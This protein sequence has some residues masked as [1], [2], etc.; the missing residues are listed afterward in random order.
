MD[1]DEVVHIY[2]GKLVRHKE[3]QN[4]G[5]CSNTDAARVSNTK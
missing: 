4:N 2:N 3:E 1:L 5:I